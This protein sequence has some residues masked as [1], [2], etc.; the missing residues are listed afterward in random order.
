MKILVYDDG[1]DLEEGD[2]GMDTRTLLQ[3]IEATIS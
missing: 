3:E 1:E 2:S